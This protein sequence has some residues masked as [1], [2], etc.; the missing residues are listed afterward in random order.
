MILKFD[1]FEKEFG[2]KKKANERK[3]FRSSIGSVF[4]VSIL[5]FFV[6]RCQ[7]ML[8][9]QFFIIK[10][11]SHLPL[12]YWWLK[13]VIKAVKISHLI[14]LPQLPVETAKKKKCSQLMNFSATINILSSSIWA[15]NW[16]TTNL[17]RKGVRSVDIKRMCYE[18]SKEMWDMS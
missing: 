3:R 5:A 15:M 11:H 1:M 9:Y 13:W 10:F 8:I 6:F 18:R 7:E 17:N 12:F 4:H 16:K 14:V 2:M